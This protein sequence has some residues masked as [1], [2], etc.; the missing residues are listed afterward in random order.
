MAASC[1]TC[2]A[3]GTISPHAS[4]VVLMPWARVV[5]PGPRTSRSRGEVVRGGDFS[6]EAETCCGDPSCRELVGDAVNWP[7]TRGVFDFVALQG[8]AGQPVPGQP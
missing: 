1:C 2:I 4:V 6:C 7:E 8:L 5:C 3:W